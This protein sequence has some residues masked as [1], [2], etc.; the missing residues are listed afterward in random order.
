MSETRLDRFKRLATQRTNAILDK[1][2]LLGNLSNKS[3]YEYTEEDLK[4]I[5]STIEIQLRTIKTRFTGSKKS[6]FKLE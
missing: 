1:L 3:S 6:E 4:K 2:R 5:F